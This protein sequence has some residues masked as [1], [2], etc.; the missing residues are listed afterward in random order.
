MIRLLALIPVPL[1]CLLTAGCGTSSN[2][3]PLYLGHVAT[4]SGSNRHLGQQET[5][6]IRLAVEQWTK[7]KTLVLDRPIH[8]KHTDAHGSLDAFETEAVRLVSVSR[9]LA[10][11]GGNTA[12]EVVRLDRAG[13]PVVTPLGYRPRGVSDATLAIGLSPR[14]QARALAHFALQE[15]KVQHAVLFL[16]ERDESLGQLSAALEREFGLGDGGQTLAKIQFGQDANWSELAGKVGPKKGEAIFFA[17][18]AKDLLD[19]RQALKSPPRLLLFAGADGTLPRGDLGKDPI[20]VATAFA[21]DPDQPR[22]KE[23]IQR[24]RSAFQEEP[25]VHAALAHDGARLFVEALRRAQPQVLE[26]LLPELRGTKDFQ[27]LTGLCTFGK[28]QVLRRPVYVGKREGT[29]FAL[30]KRYEFGKDD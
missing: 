13:A 6:G 30:L 11:Y 15:M 1:A 10:L 12:A 16:D 3:V 23:F 9:A 27:G 21:A 2:P 7:D 17:G 29:T 28:D 26:K 19:F 25:D 5:W 24:F 22:T 14:V 8:V 18:S 20:H 4:T